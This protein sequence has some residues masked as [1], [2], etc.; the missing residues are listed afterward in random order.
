MEPSEQDQVSPTSPTPVAHLGPIDPSEPHGTNTL[1]TTVVNAG[2]SSIENRQGSIP[3][4][5]VKNETL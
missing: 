5:T 1:A 2:K 3:D 4:S